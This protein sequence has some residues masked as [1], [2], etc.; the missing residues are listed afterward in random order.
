[1]KEQLTITTERVD[2]IALLVAHMQRMGLDSLPDKHFPIHGQGI[3]VVHHLGVQWGKPAH[4]L[5]R[6]ERPSVLD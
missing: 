6:Q 3:A 5:K 1:M 4:L 2:D